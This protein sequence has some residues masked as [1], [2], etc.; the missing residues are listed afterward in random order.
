MK[1]DVLTKDMFKL[2]HDEIKVILHDIRME[3]KKQWKTIMELQDRI[4][5]LEDRYGTEID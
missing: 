2:Y 3:L 5:M 1:I 4:K